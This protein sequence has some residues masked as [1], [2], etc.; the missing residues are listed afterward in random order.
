MRTVLASL[1]V[2]GPVL[3]G[4]IWANGFTSWSI[5]VCSSARW[6]T[7][8]FGGMIWYKHTTHTHTT[9]DKPCY[10]VIDI[11]A[12]YCHMLFAC[13]HQHNFQ[14]LDFMRSGYN[15]GEMR[16]S[17]CKVVDELLLPANRPQYGFV[18]VSSSVPPV[19]VQA[20]Q[21]STV[22]QSREERRLANA[23]WYVSHEFLLVRSGTLRGPR[24]YASQSLFSEC[25]NLRGGTLG[26]CVDVWHITCT[27]ACEWRQARH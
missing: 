7:A 20:V 27:R 8:G 1:M 9:N 14:I 15:E 16:S 10:L 21:T 18:V 5:G 22:I 23:N 2:D 25:T 19:N 24:R 6:P 12:C 13:L 3:I 4:L 11:F 17:H 26:M